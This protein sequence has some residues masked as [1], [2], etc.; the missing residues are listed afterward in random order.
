MSETTVVTITNRG[1]GYVIARQDAND[2]Q[3]SAERIE[4]F[5]SSRA[6]F[7]YTLLAVNN[8]TDT[9]KINP[10]MRE[11]SQDDRIYT[12]VLSAKLKKK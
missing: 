7:P 12:L 3:L 10:R 6:G 8:S 4:Y 11:V 2:Q 9:R 1:G 5:V